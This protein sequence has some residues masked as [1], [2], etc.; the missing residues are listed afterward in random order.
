[1]FVLGSDQ[2]IKAE[3]FYTNQ[4]DYFFVQS[5]TKLIFTAGLMNLDHVL[6]H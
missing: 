6:E 2:L 3:V 5:L 1:M 4:R